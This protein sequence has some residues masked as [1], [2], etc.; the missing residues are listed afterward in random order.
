MLAALVPERGTGRTA[1][2]AGVEIV[3]READALEVSP[4]GEASAIGSPI[5][6]SQWR[7]QRPT[8]ARPAKPESPRASRLPRLRF[9]QRGPIDLK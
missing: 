9:L 4:A 3:V 7:P 2:S 1:T 6:Q 5:V 8:S